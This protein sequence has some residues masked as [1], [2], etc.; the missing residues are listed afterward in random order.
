MDHVQPVLQPAVKS[1]AALRDYFQV[2]KP[3]IV[4]GNLLSVAAGFAL[5]SAGPP[6]WRLLAE[7]LA[8]VA[9]VIASACVLN[10][11]A[12]RD[13]DRIM[14]RTRM[15]ALAAGRLP[16][17]AAVLYAA[18]LGVAGGAILLICDNRLSFALVLGGYTVYAGLYSVYLKRRSAWATAV[19]SLAGAAPPLGGYCAASGSLDGGAMLLGLAF[20]LWQIAHFHAIAIRRLEDYRAAAIPVW[21]LSRG[22]AAA[23]RQM[24]GCI[25]GYIAATQTL[26]GAGPGAG[27]GVAACCVVTGG[28][29]LAWLYVVWRGDGKGGAGDGA[30]GDRRWAKH[31]FT[32]SLVALAA[33]SAAIMAGALLAPMR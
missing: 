32:G 33:L 6:D 24:L 12:D 4:A 23:R 11:V 16:P 13:L 31:G 20:C 27:P 14:A 2:I 22:L 30:G 17:R 18:A 8:G 21:P 19:G 15:R 9:L 3:G 1:G 25:V 29:G 10:N 7:T 5:A 26:V 28:A